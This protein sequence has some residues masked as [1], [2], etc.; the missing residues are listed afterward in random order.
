MITRY[1]SCDNGQENLRLSL[2][3]HDELPEQ[4]EHDSDGSESQRKQRLI[5]K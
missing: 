4:E 2:K 5:G 3:F 1:H